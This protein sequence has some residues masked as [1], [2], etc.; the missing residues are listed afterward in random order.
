[1]HV[2]SNV[3]RYPGSMVPRFSG[4]AFMTSSSDASYQRLRFVGMKSNHVGETTHQTSPL[5]PILSLS[6]FPDRSCSADDVECIAAVCSRSRHHQKLGPPR[7]G[8]ARY[9][10]LRSDVA[11]APGGRQS[12]SIG[13]EIDQDRFC[14]TCPEVCGLRTTIRSS[15][16]QPAPTSSCGARSKPQTWIDCGSKVYCS[17]IRH[18]MILDR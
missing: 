10:A 8:Q 11:S 18:T 12:L 17:E 2:T 7:P 1:M 9:H 13:D 16:E 5:R 4:P 14:E 6:W 15:C 3:Q